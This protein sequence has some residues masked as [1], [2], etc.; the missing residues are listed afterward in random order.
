MKIAIYS[1]S[2]MELE[3]KYYDLAFNI[4]YELGCRGHEL[5]Y[6]GYLYGVMGHVAKGFREAGADITAVVPEVFDRPGYGYS[7]CANVYVTKNLSDRKEKM[8]EMADIFIALPGGIGTMDELFSVMA[9]KN[10]GLT[11]KKIFVMNA[12]GLFDGL[13]KLIDRLTKEKFINGSS[14]AEIYDDAAELIAAVERCS[15][16]SM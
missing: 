16:T 13:A 12:W 4:G 10:I 1:S 15:D 14:T 3:Q 7:E 6:G 11:D 2:S 8:E 9:Q 5:V